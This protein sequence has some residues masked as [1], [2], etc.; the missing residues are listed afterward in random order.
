VRNEHEIF[1][2][3]LSAVAENPDIF[4]GILHY[5]IVPFK[6]EA[7]NKGKFDFEWFKS[8]NTYLLVRAFYESQ[9]IHKAL[10]YVVQKLSKEDLQSLINQIYLGDALKMKKV[11]GIIKDA[12]QNRPDYEQVVKGLSSA[13]KVDYAMTSRNTGGIDL[14]SADASLQ[15]QNAGQ[16]IKFQ[17]NPAL[18][19]ELQNVPG[20]IPEIIN[21]QPI[22]SLKIYLGLEDDL[23]HV[24]TS[25]A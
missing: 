12:L 15:L 23:K 13:A 22:R 4:A 18:L 21:I 14:S 1:I 20:F 2:S 16:G 6:A 24:A 3:Y 9:N 10:P 25:T 11:R 8:V 5:A 17:F 7:L 19:K